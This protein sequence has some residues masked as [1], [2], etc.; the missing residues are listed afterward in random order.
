MSR[1]PRHPISPA[2]ER[3]AEEERVL[4]RLGI[5]ERVSTQR[6]CRPGGGALHPSKPDR[7]VETTRPGGKGG[8]TMRLRSARVLTLHKATKDHGD[9]VR[10]TP[11]GRIL[12]E[13]AIRRPID[14]KVA[15]GLLAELGYPG[16]ELDPLTC[17]PFCALCGE[18]T[19][20]HWCA[21]L[22]LAADDGCRTRADFV[23]RLTRETVAAADRESALPDAPPAR[24]LV[25]RD[26]R[27]RCGQPRPRLKTDRRAFVTCSKCFAYVDDEQRL[28]AATSGASA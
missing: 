19:C 15:A 2:Q 26:G 21:A 1:Q 22:I 11:L 18:K 10:L 5:L 16:A 12:A 25:T 14:R 3:E 4:Q 17:A 7:P 8:P 27:A 9:S 23:Q 6:T 13:R 24:H 28:I 20:P